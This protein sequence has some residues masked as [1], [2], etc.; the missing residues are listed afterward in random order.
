MAGSVQGRRVVNLRH[1]WGGCPL[2]WAGG[3]PAPNSRLDGSSVLCGRKTSHLLM[4]DCLE[5][6][7]VGAYE[8]LT[9]TF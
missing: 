8:Y 2:K 6:M 9:C 7:W 4:G 3:S 5:R 1:D